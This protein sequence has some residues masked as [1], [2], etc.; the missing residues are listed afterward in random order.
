MRP[1]SDIP[2]DPKNNSPWQTHHLT[3]AEGPLIPMIP[4]GD[5]AVAGI[6]TDLRVSA[7]GDLLG[8]SEI[9]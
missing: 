9:L 4:A 7:S 3:V 6:K 8:K 2:K 5:N 1:R